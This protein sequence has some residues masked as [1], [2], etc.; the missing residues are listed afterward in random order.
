MCIGTI[1]L[2]W[3]QAV[4]EVAP[5]CGGLRYLASRSFADLC[6][7]RIDLSAAHTADCVSRLLRR[8]A[9]G[10]QWCPRLR[11]DCRQLRRY[12]REAPIIRYSATL[13]WPGTVPSL[14]LGWPQVGTAA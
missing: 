9:D 1:T 2:R 3:G 6:L 14:I 7:C 5:D 4:W 11:G 10:G 13:I 12:S 8:G